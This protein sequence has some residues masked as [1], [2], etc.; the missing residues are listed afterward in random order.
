VLG[1][2]FHPE[3]TP[4]TLELLLENEEEL[5]IFNGEYVQPVSQLTLGIYDKFNRFI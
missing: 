5:S 4:A 2:Q 1:F 3:M